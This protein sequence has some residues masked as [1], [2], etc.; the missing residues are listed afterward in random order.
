[1]LKEQ[2]IQDVVTQ[3][4]IHRGDRILVAFSGG[5]DSLALLSLL[6]ELAPVLGF[7]LGAVHMNHGL[8]G[9]SADEDEEFCRAFAKERGIPFYSR[10]MDI[11]ALAEAKGWSLEMAGREARYAFFK[12]VMVQENYTACATAHHQDDLRETILLH[13]FRGTGLTGLSGMAYKR[14]AFIRPLLSVEKEDILTYLEGKGLTPREDET[15]GDPAFLRNRIRHELIPYIQQHFNGDF[16]QT[17]S[18]MARTLREDREFIEEE[19][20]KVR[21]AVL[22]EEEDQQ[23]HPKVVLDKATFTLPMALRI[24]MIREAVVLVKGDLQNI[25]EVHLR[26]IEALS[27]KA[28]GKMLDVKEEIMARNEYGHVVLTQKPAGG[29][30]EVQYRLSLPGRVLV[31]GRRV[32]AKVVPREALGRDPRCRYFDRGAFGEEI[33]IRHREDG[34]KMKPLGMTGTRKVKSILIDKKMSRE[35]RDRLLVLV[36]NKEIFSLDNQ[37]ISEDYK[38][39]ESTQE[40]LEIGIYEE[41]NT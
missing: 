18:R 2:V 4:L 15:N 36:S 5:S 20:H 14:D 11:E 26:D 19:V 31:E 24:R 37:V 29:R 35:D 9:V 34:D 40:V 22:R 30:S 13:L 3:G 6:Y 38:I 10:K 39:K 8:R 28:T 7:T 27:R 33:L 17:L 16:P 21:S 12:E 32:E 41:E 25:E 23:G 1:M